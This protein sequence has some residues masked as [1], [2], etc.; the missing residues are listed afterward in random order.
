MLAEPMTN[1]SPFVVKSQKVFGV[2]STL[3]LMA[4]TAMVFVNRTVI[5]KGKPL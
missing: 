3:G 1:G 4:L 2:I 5:Q